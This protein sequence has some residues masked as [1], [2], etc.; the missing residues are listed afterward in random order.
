MKIGTVVNIRVSPTNC[1]A[2]S[3]AIRLAGL[4]P[5]DMTFSSAVSR[6]L[7]MM[8]DSLRRD[9]L[10][11]TRDGFELSNMMEEFIQKNKASLPSVSYR[12]PTIREDAPRSHTVG[13]DAPAVQVASNTA[14]T[15][16]QRMA[17]VRF[18][19][20]MVK[21]EHAPDSWTLGDEREL[22]QVLAL[23]G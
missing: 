5:G 8:M 16:E 23:M 13:T 21:R 3:D 20:L 4:H 2:I 22:E 7:D 10:I 12:Q 6:V 14:T 18:K 19:E 9:N 11:P 17:N 15:H 1:M